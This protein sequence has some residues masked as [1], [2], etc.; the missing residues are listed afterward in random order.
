MRMPPFFT[1]MLLLALLLTGCANAS[2]PITPTA[3]PTANSREEVDFGC[4][5]DADCAVKNVGNCC[6]YFPACVNAN[7]P[8][9]PERVRAEC[10]RDGVSGICGF[11]EISA[12]ACV[13]G[14]CQAADAG[15]MPD[16]NHGATNAAINRE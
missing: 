3:P 14:Q 6:G 11:A 9:F 10:E 12:C 16:A 5:V 2:G 13:D 1:L 4:T 8:V 7:S 15:A